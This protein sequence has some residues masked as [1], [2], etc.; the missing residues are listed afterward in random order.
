MHF[1]YL[2]LILQ[3]TSFFVTIR[4]AH[5]TSHIDEQLKEFHCG[6]YL[7]KQE[8]YADLQK[9]E[10]TAMEIPIFWNLSAGVRR[11]MGDT[12]DKRIVLY[13]DSKLDELKFFNL[14]TLSRNYEESGKNIFKGYYL[15]LDQSSRVSGII[16][17][18]FE[19]NLRP[20]LK[21]PPRETFCMCRIDV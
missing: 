14:K 20:N 15:I 4:A 1:S 2:A 18:T 13:G 16:E 17:R 3:S 5:T 10:I 11:A 12:D 9:S 21:N 19:T 8:N 6:E 7:L